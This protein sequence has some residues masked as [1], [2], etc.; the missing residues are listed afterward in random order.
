MLE[1]KVKV[2]VLYELVQLRHIV[3]YRLLLLAE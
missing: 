3:I 1:V 2:K